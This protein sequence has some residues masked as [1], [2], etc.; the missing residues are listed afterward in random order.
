MKKLFSFGVLFLAAVQFVLAQQVAATGT[1][2]DDQGNPVQYAF[3]R[4][5]PYNLATFS[6]S[7]G[8]FKMMVYPNS[9]LLVVCKGYAGTTVNTAGN[10]NFD[11]VLKHLNGAAATEDVAGKTQGSVEQGVSRSNQNFQ[12]ET[13]AVFAPSN[14]GDA[15]GSQYFYDNWAHGF[16]IDTKDSLVENPDYLY[17]YDKIGGDLL[18]TKDA[19]SA[20]AANRDQVKSFTLVSNNGETAVFAKVPA[21]DNAHYLQVLASGK[22]YGIYKLVT[23]KFVKSDYQTNGV[24]SSGN[25]YDEYVNTGT[26]YVLNVAANQVQPLLLKKK[27]VKAAFATDA[28]KVNKYMTDHSSDIDD[29]YLSDLGAYLNN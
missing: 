12:F 2:K 29:A 6:D 13:G 16:V 22:K 3:V 19:K 18:F 14:K 15:R 9:A 26:Y 4:D 7:L 1:V 28:D 21:I 20:M 10:T 11:V 23:T 24:S 8:N 5:R 27:A 17:N 25:N